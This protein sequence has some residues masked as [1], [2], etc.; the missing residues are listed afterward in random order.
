MPNQ[1]VTRE[2]WVAARQAL[3]AKEKAFT[4][5]RDAL[6]AERQALPWVRVKTDYAFDGPGG[7]ETLSDLFAGR[8]QLIVY[9]F[10]FEP[11][12]E[13]GCKGCSFLSD[14]FDPAIVHLNER[15]VSFVVASTAPWQ[16]TNAFKERMGWRFKWVSAGNCSFNRDYHVTFDDEAVAKGEVYYNF[17]PFPFNMKEAPGVSVFYKDGDGTIYHT[18]SSYAR[19]LDAFIGAYQFLDI[20]PKGRDE[21]GLAF[22]MEWVKHHDRYEE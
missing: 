2:E 20:V 15:D 8:T 14:H 7:T 11:Q 17:G 4:R 16:T 1:I 9:H 18:Y 12:W 13:E 19:G 6:S 3:L 22:G 21:E 5:E 10:M